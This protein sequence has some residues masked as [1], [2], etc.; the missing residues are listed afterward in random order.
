MADAIVIGGGV[1]GL[2]IARE[3]RRRGRSVTLLERATPGKAAS[4]ASAGIL[5]NTAGRALD[6]VDAL[7]AASLPV[8]PLLAAELREESGLDIDYGWQVGQVEYWLREHGFTE[9]STPYDEA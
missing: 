3:L 8:F 5:A 4:W 2:A 1:M 6:A 7:V 9:Q